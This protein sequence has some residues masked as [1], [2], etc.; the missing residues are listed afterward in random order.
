MSHQSLPLATVTRGASSV[1]ARS[2]LVQAR[3]ATAP[4]ATGLPTRLPGSVREVAAGAPLLTDVGVA[5]WSRRGHSRGAVYAISNGTHSGGPDGAA[6]LPDTGSLVR[7]TRG[8]GFR[9]TL[10]GLDRPTS[11]ELRHGTAYVVNLE[12]EV[13]AVPLRR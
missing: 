5:A 9:V 8:G 6:G 2:I 4:Y 7:A 11:L 1:T 13:W 10:A 12:G 3:S